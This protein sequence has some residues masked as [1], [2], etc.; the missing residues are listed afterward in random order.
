VKKRERDG[1]GIDSR[2]RDCHLSLV[3]KKAV[4]RGGGGGKKEGVL[5]D[6]REVSERSSVLSF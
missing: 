4:G 3:S 2:M 5:S 6:S 1:Q